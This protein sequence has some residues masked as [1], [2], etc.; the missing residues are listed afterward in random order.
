M[1]QKWL[2]WAEWNVPKKAKVNHTFLPSSLGQ[3]FTMLAV[4]VVLVSSLMI[5]GI[6]RKLSNTLNSS[7]FFSVFFV[8][9]L[10]C[11]LIFKRAYPVL[12]LYMQS[13]MRNRL[14]P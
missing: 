9:F 12:L 6:E 14:T 10:T 8:R 11:F 2:H 1:Y 4:V 3:Q 13:R 5:D 7:N